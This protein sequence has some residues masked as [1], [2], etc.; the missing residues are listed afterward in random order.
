MIQIDWNQLERNSNSKEISFERFCFHYAS[1]LLKGYGE[2]TY[3]YNAAGSEFYLELAKPL[4]YDGKK[5]EKG[6]VIGW[7]AKFWVNH[8]DMDNSSLTADRRSELTEGFKLTLKRKSNL[9]L[10]VVCTPGQFKEDAYKTLKDGLAEVKETVNVTHWHKAI[11][12]SAFVGENGYKFQGLLAFYFGKRVIERTLLDGISQATINALREKFDVDLHTATPFENRLMSII[13]KEKACATICEKAKL[14]GKRLARY[15]K[16]WFKEDGT[17]D[18]ERLKAFGKPFEEAFLAYETCVLNMSRHILAIVSCKN[19]DII[20]KE[21]TDYLNAQH[22]NFIDCAKNVEKEIRALKENVKEHTLYFYTEDIIELKDMLFGRAEHRDESI[23]HT[24]RLRESRYFP[25]FAQAGHGKTHFACSMA[26]EQLKKGLPVLLLTGSRFR[27]CDSPQEVIMRILEMDDSNT[28]FDE[29]IGALDL[30]ASNYPAT[31]MPVIIDGLNE[32]FPNERVWADELPAIVAAFEKSENLILVTTCREKTEYVQKIYGQKSYEKV[33][34]ASLLKGIDD[35]NL[36]DTIHKYFRKYGI[37]ETSIAD[38]TIFRNPLL[39]KIFSETNRGT[40]GVAVNEH[41]LVESMKKYSDDLV[42]K[43]SVKDG[44][45]NKQI[46]Y[47]VRK[48][49]L[50][51]G[52]MLWERNTRNVDY[53][54]DFC[55][56]FGEKSEA[57]LEEGLCFQVEAL[58]TDGGE[59]KFTY[60]LLAGYHIAQW[61][62]SQANSEDRLVA[63]LNEDTIRKKLFGTPNELHTLAEDI[64]KTLTYSAREKT[65]KSLFELVSDEKAFA[66]ILENVE[67]IKA[68]AEEQ[69][70]LKARLSKSL[71]GDVKRAVCDIVRRKLIEHH[72]VSGLSLLLPAFIQFSSEEFDL[73][74]Y[75][76]FLGYGKQQEAACTIKK[77]LEGDFFLDD[78]V[79]AAVLISGCFDEKVRHEVVRLM[80]EH[81]RQHFDGLV[82]FLP[83]YLRLSDPNIR[84][85]VYIT[86]H[87]A[88]VGR[89]NKSNTEDAVRIITDDL[90]QRPTSN[91]V[92]LDY[93]DSVLCYANSVFATDV[94]KSVLLLA[95][96]AKWY[97]TDCKEKWKSETYDYEFEKN[98]IRP[99]SSEI[100]DSASPFTSDQLYSMILLKMEEN[101]Y[102]DNVYAD[103]QATHRDRMKYYQPLID[104]IPFKHVRATQKELVGWLMLNGVIEPEYMHSLRSTELDVDPSFPSVRPKRQLISAS[105]LPRVID[106]KSTWLDINPLAEL[107]QFLTMKFKG[108]DAEW[109]LLEG[110]L[111]QKHDEKEAQLYWRIDGGLAH[112]DTEDKKIELPAKRHSHLLASEIDWRSMEYS[113]DDYFDAEL[114]VPLLQHYEFT[115]WETTRAENPNFYFLADQIQKD[116]ALEFRVMELAYFRNGEKVTVYFMDNHSEFYYIRKDLLKEIEERYNVSLVTE[117]FAQKTDTHREEGRRTYRA[118]KEY[119]ER[120]IELS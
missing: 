48:G 59:V 14:L 86:I 46:S 106:D 69:E 50:K 22:D 74:L 88:T 19:V 60:D 93:S 11:F 62:L 90:R 17:R 40:R 75:E 28:S 64:I 12:E 32:S 25:V 99:Y 113:H 97:V 96:D 1:I 66:M 2:M 3:P 72:S 81:A 117:L 5:Y 55:E 24:L 45:E 7:Q 65:N 29:L 16:R 58:N 95:K 4:E 84:E 15:E 13:D 107:K 82:D 31:R 21:G 51:M 111:I 9:A 26:S 42:S 37:E 120:I 76:Q 112:N 108:S 6:D 23:E 119:K 39:L 73:H 104:Q 30:L 57:L 35:F 77:G 115:D 87:G 118:Y 105:F 47:S 20:Y 79:M 53:F 100:Y 71:N 38:K 67:L 63:L 52:Q 36:Q 68:S 56:I 43:L 78:A 27:R 83:T 110:H 61:L 49:L 91:V 116:F 54:G 33:D 102:C 94:D 44:A 89:G 41:T 80:T 18:D 92:L 101:G 103:L 109:V 85:A 34:N 10:W 98:Y 70:A 8:N 114:G